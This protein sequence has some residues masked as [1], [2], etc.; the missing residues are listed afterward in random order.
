MAMKYE[1]TLSYTEA[2][3]IA[4]AKKYW[5]RKYSID[6]VLSIHVLGAVSYLFFVEGYQNWAVGFLLAIALIYTITVY[7]GFFVWRGRSLSIFRAMGGSLARWSFTDDAFICESGAGKAELKWTTIKKLWR[8]SD[9]WLLF[10]A[11]G[12]YSTLPVETL[13]GEAKNFIEQK[14]REAGGHIA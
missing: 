10:Y 6:A 2:M 8:Y 9:V 5:L 14:I 1:T 3:I 7:A 12:T 11:S 13:S 4:A